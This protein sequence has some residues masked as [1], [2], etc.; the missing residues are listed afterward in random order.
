[1]TKVHSFIKSVTMK[2]YLFRT[3]LGFLL[4]VSC[5]PPIDTSIITVDPDIFSTPEEF[6]D[7]SDTRM[8]VLE[9]CPDN[10]ITSIE[11]IEINDNK[12]FIEDEASV[13]YVFD[14]DGNYLYKI[15]HLGKGP[16]EYLQLSH[17]D[18]FESEL[19]I[20]STVER[21]IN[22]YTLEGDFKR[23]Y[24]IEDTDWH[25][26][27]QIQYPIAYLYAEYNSQ[28]LKSLTI[29]DLEKSEVI[30]EHMPIDR[31]LGHVLSRSP[32]VE[33]DDKSIFLVRSYDYNIYKLANA[34]F[35][36]AYQLDFKTKD[37]MP[38]NIYE[39][40]MLDLNFSMRFK[41]CVTRIDYPY[42]NGDK[43]Y[44]S[45]IHQFGR[46]LTQID[47]NDQSSK[48]ISL[49]NKETF[50]K[51]SPRPLSF[52]S[53]RLILKVD[54]YIALEANPH[55]PSNKNEDGLLKEDDNPIIVLQK[56]K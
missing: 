30:S 48:S 35:E 46:R 49:Y 44:I 28:K 3:L 33:N 51:Y 29:Y 32:F 43:L 6:F 55:F 45:Y 27:M 23:K 25:T 9:T 12:L 17:F 31:D 36:I 37:K 11:N 40:D 39:G 42:L 56:M 8:I 18:I 34:Q 41:E 24:K 10:L 15:D 20:L 7:L 2:N 52:K 21:K 16:H 1:M 13:I 53:G 38:D 14:I 26:S 47:L 4:I 22:V 5:K 54:P 19:Y 50:L